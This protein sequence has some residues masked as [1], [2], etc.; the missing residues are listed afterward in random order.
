MIYLDKVEAYWPSQD[1]YLGRWVYATVTSSKGASSDKLEK[2]I[3]NLKYKMG[4]GAITQSCQ[5]RY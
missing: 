2:E 5:H 3:R 1:D 4:S